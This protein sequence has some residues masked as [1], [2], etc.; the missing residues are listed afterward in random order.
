MTSPG[1]TNPTQDSY[2]KREGDSCLAGYDVF[3]PCLFNRLRRGGMCPVM[4]EYL[5]LFFAAVES[6]PE[7]FP[8]IAE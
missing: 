2:V 6:F 4:E 1:Y 8:E 7:I 5:E 3:P